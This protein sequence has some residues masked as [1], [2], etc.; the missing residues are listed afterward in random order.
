MS[1]QNYDWPDVGSV[2]YAG[3]SAVIPPAGETFNLSSGGVTVNVMSSSILV[4]FPEGWLFSTAPKTFDGIVVTDLAANI[5]G[6]A[7]G[8]TNISGYVASELS[9]DNNNLYIDF[10]YPPLSTLAAG[11]SVSVDVQFASVPEPASFILLSVGLFGIGLL[12]RRRSKYATV[13]RT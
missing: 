7:L 13:L 12:H 6:D 11:A 4:T 2:L 8:S 9:F 1:P 10:P 3:G 5:M